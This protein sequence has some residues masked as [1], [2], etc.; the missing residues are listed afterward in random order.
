MG[1]ESILIRGHRIGSHYTSQAS[2]QESLHCF[3]FFFFFEVG[4]LEAQDSLEF[5]KLCLP[6]SGITA[7][8]YPSWLESVLFAQSICEQET[9]ASKPIP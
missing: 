3:N 9:P 5:L 2:V 7:T 4:S 6:V 1:A 8:L